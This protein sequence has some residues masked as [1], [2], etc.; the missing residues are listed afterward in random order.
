MR[1]QPVLLEK[2]VPE[3]EYVLYCT[4]VEPHQSSIRAMKNQNRSATMISPICG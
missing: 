2:Q 3:N 1:G 4:R